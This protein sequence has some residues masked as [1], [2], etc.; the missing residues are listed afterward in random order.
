[1]IIATH[2]GTFHADETTACAILSYLFDNVSVIRSRDADELEKA[3]IIIDVSNMNDEKHFDHHS[4]DFTLCRENGIKYATAG[5][6][7]KKFGMDY[8]RKI[9]KNELDFH[10]SEKVLANAFKR[11]DCDI[12]TMIDLNDNGQLTNYADSIADAKT[13]HEKELVNSLNELYQSSPDI[14]YI[15]AMMNLPK[16]TGQEQDKAFGAVV[17]MLKSI[18]LSASINAISTESGIAKVLE[19]YQGGPILII[20]ERLPWTQAVLSNMDIFKDCKLAMYPDRNMRWRVQSLPVS[21]AQRFKNRLSA[22]VA[23]RGLNDEELD[24][25]TGLKNMTF[26]HKSGFTGGANNHDDCRKLANLWLEQ[27]VED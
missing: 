10:P 25:V 5:L 24:K 22:P 21:K 8:L 26:I 6:M 1:M 16:S 12:M 4:K 18:I 17:K 23:W 7:W 19:A 3:D 2:D 14:P 13:E 11:I 9:V 27:G 20:H 15:V